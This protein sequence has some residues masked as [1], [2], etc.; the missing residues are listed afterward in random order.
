MRPPYGVYTDRV[1]E[2]VAQLN[3]TPVMWKV[4]SN[5][6]KYYLQGAE[7][8]AAEVIEQTEIETGMTSV[9]HLGHDLQL[10][11]VEAI[12]TVID[13][14]RARNWT[15][16]SMHECLGVNPDVLYQF[17]RREIS[18]GLKKTVILKSADDLAYYSEVPLQDIL[19]LSGEASA[20][21]RQTTPNYWLSFGSVLLMTAFLL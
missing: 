10:E 9:I 2:L 13:H 21:V 6:W 20:A 17:Q 18:T 4:D 19:K 5:D 14:I 3:Y 12:A 15:I 8:I 11:S 7:R 1:K 16:I